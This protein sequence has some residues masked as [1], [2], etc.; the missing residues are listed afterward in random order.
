MQRFY[1]LRITCVFHL[2]WEES[3]RLFLEH[4]QL[5]AQ[6][7]EKLTHQIEQIHEHVMSD[8]QFFLEKILDL[9]TKLVG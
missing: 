9:Q 8:N 3:M 1:V 6:W 5:V 7:L 4:F 2:L